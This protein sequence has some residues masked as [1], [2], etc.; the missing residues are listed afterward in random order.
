[1][2]SATTRPRSITAMRSASWSASS[3]YCVVSRTVEPLATRSR[4]VP[5][6]WARVRG[7]RPVVGS[8]RKMR[9]GWAMRL[10]A[11]SSRRR[12]PPEKFFNGRDAASESP[13]ASSSST[14][15]RR[16]CPRESPSSRPKITRFSVALSVSSTDAY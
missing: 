6:I 8:S 7:S 16:A 15:L 2:P 9:G 3:R 12:M 1:M 14:A 13:N 5:H 11:R 4:I 10:A